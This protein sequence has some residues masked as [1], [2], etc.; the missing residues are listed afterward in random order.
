MVCYD[1]RVAVAGGQS[2]KCLIS[3][4]TDVG[5]LPAMDKSMTTTRKLSSEKQDWLTILAS[6]HTKS[7]KRP[8][9]IPQAVK[10]A[11]RVGGRGLNPTEIGWLA[12]ELL[13]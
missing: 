3:C 1:I 6:N 12:S 10:M 9:T 8:T 5:T 7:H 11:K 4:G 13:G 2:R